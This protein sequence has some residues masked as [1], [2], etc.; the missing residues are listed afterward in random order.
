MEKFGYCEREAHCERRPYGIR[1]EAVKRSA[2]SAVVAALLMLVASSAQAYVPAPP[3][4]LIATPS[5][6]ANVPVTVEIPGPAG[7]AAVLRIL[8]GDNVRSPVI[9]VAGVT[10]S[11]ATIPSSGIA[12]FSVRFAE[13]GTYELTGLVDGAVVANQ[14]VTVAAT[15]GSQELSETGFSLPNLMGVV[16]VAAVAILLGGVGVVIAAR[17]RE[18]KA[19]VSA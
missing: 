6:T 2:V 1:G 7:S 14:V 11:T 3:G 15:A 10:E 12:T 4:L 17:R 19:P 9:D 13:P 16:G 5:P 8:F 18:T